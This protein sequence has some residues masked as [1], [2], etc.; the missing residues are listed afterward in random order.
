MVLASDFPIFDPVSEVLENLS[1]QELIEL[2]KTEQQARI[3]QEREYQTQL[4]KK[5]QQVAWHK[6][7]IALLKRLI[8]GAKRERFI[9]SKDQLLLPFEVNQQFLDSTDYLGHQFLQRFE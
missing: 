5:D 8:F 1:K 9:P 7:I 4:T 6:H 3:V 2:V